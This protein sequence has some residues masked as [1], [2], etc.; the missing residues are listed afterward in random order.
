ML[1]TI[2]VY[3]AAPNFD[4][5]APSSFASKRY[6][7]DGGWQR[8]QNST[9]KERAA[10]VK[11]P[12]VTWSGGRPGRPEDAL[13]IE[14]SLPKL[15]FGNNLSELAEGDARVVLRLLS[16]AVAEMGVDVTEE[17]LWHSKVSL[18]H[19]G[20]NVRLS[21]GMTCCSAL[22]ELSSV[23]QRATM[24]QT[25]SEFRNGGA[26]Y[27]LHANQREITFYDKLLDIRRAMKSPKRAEDPLSGKLGIP[28][29][30][31]SG[32][33]G[34]VLRMECRFSKREG[35]KDALRRIGEANPDPRF[36]DVFREDV[37]MGILLREL[38]RFEGPA[39]ASPSGRLAPLDLI[40]S[41]VKGG[42]TSKNAITTYGLQALEREFQCATL[43]RVLEES[44][45][46]AAAWYR[47]RRFRS[48]APAT[49]ADSAVHVI[50]KALVDYVP[51]QMPPKASS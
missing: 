24:D 12:A 17:A 45:A 29:E 48:T 3:L 6:F 44:G 32:S 46:P 4:V 39:G 38:E 5:T 35:V 30:M 11:K 49:S 28:G 43:R 16:K 13:R 40:S 41:L 33:A 1:D 21:P 18:L 36:S 26:A 51:F 19:V 37:A 2:A 22:W 15:V 7:P 8:S 20:K 9:A 14:V 31:D 42:M 27:K 34:A 10:N 50:R 23:P 47:L 25:Q